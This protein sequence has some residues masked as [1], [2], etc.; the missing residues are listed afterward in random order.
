MVQQEGGGIY[1]RL[2]HGVLGAIIRSG[3]NEGSSDW[4]RRAG[5]GSGPDISHAGSVQTYCDHEYT[6]MDSGRWTHRDETGPLLRPKS[7]VV[8]RH[9]DEVFQ[10]N[11]R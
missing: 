1:R 7:H 4:S 5:E 6:V 9:P 2:K 3:A 10:P 8:L 11:H